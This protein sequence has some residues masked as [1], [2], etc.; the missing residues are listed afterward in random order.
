MT[1]RCCPSGKVAE[2]RRH[3]M[4]LACRSRDADKPRVGLLCSKDHLS[5]PQILE[6]DETLFALFE[7]SILS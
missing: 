3:S 2:R 6:T 1:D 5:S 4:D 7:P